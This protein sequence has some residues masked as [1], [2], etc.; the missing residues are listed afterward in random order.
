MGMSGLD[1]S[2][3]VEARFESREQL[4]EAL[5]QD[6]DDGGLFIAGEHELPAGEQ[7][8]V[9]M[10]LDGIEPGLVMGATI[11]WRRL[12]RGSRVPAGLGVSFA[13][14]ESARFEFLRSVALSGGEAHD[15]AGTRFPT[16]IPV[17][18]VLSRETSVRSGTIADVSEGGIL[19]HATPP[20]P[21]AQVVVLRVRDGRSGP[22][23]PTRVIWSGGDSAG[24]MVL[25]DRPEVRRFWDRIVAA[26]RGDLEARLVR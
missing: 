24:L 9:L 12:S 15:R 4:A 22:P 18:Y 1:E 23:V 6:H 7:I 17:A 2:R 14:R 5:L 26:A 19:L 13:D 10:R 16:S 3:V 8:R 11:L 21:E 20:P 25:S